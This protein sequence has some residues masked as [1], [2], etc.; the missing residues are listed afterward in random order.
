MTAIG[1]WLSLAGFQSFIDPS[2]KDNI[3]WSMAFENLKPSRLER[4]H[5]RMVQELY[6]KRPVR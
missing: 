5:R 6:G 2:R 3:L 1:K 4:D